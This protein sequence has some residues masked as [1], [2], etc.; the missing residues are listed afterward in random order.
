[1]FCSVFP[2]WGFYWESPGEYS[3]FFFS[4]RFSLFSIALFSLLLCAEIEF[5]NLQKIVTFCSLVTTKTVLLSLYRHLCI[6]PNIAGRIIFRFVEFLLRSL[7]CAANR[8]VPERRLLSRTTTE[9]FIWLEKRH[10]R[11]WFIVWVYVTVF[12]LFPV[13]R[14]NL[15]SSNPVFRAKIC[16]HFDVPNPLYH[17]LKRWHT[18]FSVWSVSLWT[19]YFIKKISR[20]WKRCA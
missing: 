16:D 19:E 8:I 2:F 18:H 3:L 1:M 9:R 15:T 7:G 10:L 5:S 12:T 20:D 14:A 11:G 13:F 4:W 6:K 17:R